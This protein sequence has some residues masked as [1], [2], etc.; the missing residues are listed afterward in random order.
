M[1]F[2]TLAEFDWFPVEANDHLNSLQV[3]DAAR[4]VTRLTA[5]TFT[6]LAVPWR[7]CFKFY[8]TG[9]KLQVNNKILDKAICKTNHKTAVSTLIFLPIVILSLTQTSSENS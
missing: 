5:R 6:D 2:T 7:Q 3:I 9:E 1:N 8:D 4:S